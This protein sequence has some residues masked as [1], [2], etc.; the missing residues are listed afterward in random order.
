MRT[1]I[2][3]GAVAALL[4][5][6]LYRHVFHDV[7]PRG[8][9]MDHIKHFGRKTQPYLQQLEENHYTIRYNIPMPSSSSATAPASRQK[10]LK[11][12]HMTDFHADA[13]EE[14]TMHEHI[15]SS[16][17]ESLEREKPDYIVLTGDF[18]HWDPNKGGT[19]FI[20]KV[21][22]PMVQLMKRLHHGTGNI[23]RVYGVMGNHD[24]M[25]PG[26]RPIYTQKLQEQV[27]EFKLLINEVVKLQVPFSSSPLLV[28]LIGVDDLIHG[29]INLNAIVESTTSKQQHTQ[30]PSINIA[31]QHNPDFADCLLLHSDNRK[32]STSTTHP[33][34]YSLNGKC[35]ELPHIDLMLSGHTHG[36]RSY[37]LRIVF[38][39]VKI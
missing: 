29:N 18:I 21:L 28:N 24:L 25:L 8:S 4:V 12:A 37:S 3:V 16:M 15:L 22:K 32:Y 6:A 23:N 38:L 31:L 7:N 13:G 14:Y 35:S 33:S 20:E 11:I 9:F 34:P 17:L 30:Q 5:A 10:L 2:M 19:V 1:V 39:M 27:P 36:V 26:W